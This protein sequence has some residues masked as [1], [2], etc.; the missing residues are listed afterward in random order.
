MRISEVNANGDVWVA[1]NCAENRPFVYELRSNTLTELKFPGSSNLSVVE[2]NSRGEAAGT[3]VK[4]GAYA[5]DG[6]TAL[7]W[8]TDPANPIDLNANQK[9]APARAWNVR[10]TDINEAGTFLAGYNDTIGNFYTFL[11]QPN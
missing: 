10:S 11:L 5:P 4:H 2:V 9:F 1:G 6:Y 7:L 8:S 3:A